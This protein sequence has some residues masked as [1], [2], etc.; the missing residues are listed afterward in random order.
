M[1]TRKLTTASILSMALLLGSLASPAVASTAFTDISDS[2]AKDAINKLAD[3]GILKG[4][5]NGRFNPTGD[6][7]R[8]DFAIVLSKALNLNTSTPPQTATFKDVSSDS[9]AFAAVEAAYKAGLVSGTGNGKFS[10]TQSLTREQ[11]AVIFVNAL[12][13]DAT[14]KGTSLSFADYSSVSPWAKE[15]VAA[16][17]EH[18]LMTG[19]SNGTLDPKGIA[20]RQQ[21]AL[22]TSK[23]LTK[24]TE[25]EQ[26]QVVIPP[27]NPEPEQE[28]VKEPEKPST[29]SPNT[30]PSTTPTVPDSNPNPTP[31]P[32]PEPPLNAAPI[33]K[34][35]SFVF[36]EETEILVV[37]QQVSIHF[38]YEDAEDDQLVSTN[39]AWYRS[40]N[41]EGRNK[42]LI[43]D[44]NNSSYTFTEEDVD[45][46]I[47]VEV[48]PNAA[49]GTTTGLTS[50]KVLDRVIM[51]PI[52]EDTTPPSINTT[53]FDVNDN[54][55]GTDD[56]LF[57]IESAISEENAVVR[58]YP[59]LDTNNIGVID[60][61][62]LREPIILGTSNVDGSLD[63]SSIGDLAPGEYKF[64]ITATD[65][66]LNESEISSDYVITVSLTKDVQV[67]ITKSSESYGFDGYFA[68]EKESVAGINPI[69]FRLDYV[70]GEVFENGT[71]EI[72][73]PDGFSFGT[74]D[75][76]FDYDGSGAW[77]NFTEDQI[78]NDG[79]TITFTG[80]SGMERRSILLYNQLIPQEGIYTFTFIGDADGAESSKAPSEPHYCTLRSVSP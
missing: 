72:T 2:Y 9:Y 44:S 34:D 24:K 54:Y 64:A 76:Y 13:V 65:E 79:K 31:N 49:T 30:P 6:I 61:G 43:P 59:W 45:H 1:R 35:L 4:T 60:E 55:N 56:Q 33:A 37:G 23:F 27:T 52:I 63:P 70:T 39:Y 14:G 28:P 8:Q 18:Q 62:E 21:V 7:S 58:A 75:K 68:R 3:A 26:E 47:S 36:E 66:A 48:T 71:L 17:L 53:K 57:G 38:D 73:V 10:G 16:A 80:I 22:V 19:N 50:Y 78:I 25:L 69:T 46:Y 67:Q 29:P 51:E 74:D 41:S 32:N 12:G 42:E 20:S 15:Y 5:G 40:S 77:R 11:M